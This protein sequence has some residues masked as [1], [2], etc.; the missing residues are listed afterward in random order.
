MAPGGTVALELV[1]DDRASLNLDLAA[2]VGMFHSEESYAQV[3][4]DSGSVSWQEAF[5]SVGLSGSIAVGGASQIYGNLS[6][7]ISAI[8]EIKAVSPEAVKEATTANAI[9]LYGPLSPH[10]SS[11]AS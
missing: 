4:T 7:A 10:P 5:G 8:A 9:R 11:G 3:R 6:L 2:D 1:K